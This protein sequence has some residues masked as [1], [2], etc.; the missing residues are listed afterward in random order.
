[1]C[2]L[3]VA[4]TKV[5]YCLNKMDLT[6]REDA[7]EKF[8]RLGLQK[9]PQ[10]VLNVSAKTGYNIEMVK[11]LMKSLVLNDHKPLVGEVRG[12]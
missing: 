11:D 8:D 7:R 6:N 10:Y 1:M 2:E 4:M 9:S 12:T 3:G 5:V